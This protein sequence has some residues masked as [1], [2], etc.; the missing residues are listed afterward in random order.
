MTIPQFRLHWKYPGGL[1]R[2][3]AFLSG[4]GP[5]TYPESR[6]RDLAAHL[7]AMPKMVEMGL[8]YWAEA[9]KATP[10]ERPSYPREGP[11]AGRRHLRGL[12]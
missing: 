9:V 2:K 11:G 1:P 3:G 4:C 8:V 10:V 6:A 12:E 7:N 5:A